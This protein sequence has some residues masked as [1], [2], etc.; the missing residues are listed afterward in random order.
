M[1]MLLKQARKGYKALI[2]ENRQTLSIKVLTDPSDPWSGSTQKPFTGRISHER[3]TISNLQVGTVGLD[4]NLGRFLSVE[5]DV[6][7]LKVGDII[8]D[9]NSKGWKLGAVDPLSKFGGVHGYQ[10]PLEEA[11]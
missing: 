10:I 2:D 3:K 6:D 11:V 9:E 4:T 7:F 5:Y 8:T 1:N